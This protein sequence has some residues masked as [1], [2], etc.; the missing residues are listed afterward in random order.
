MV[1]LLA[2]AFISGMITILSPCI[3]P[4]LPIVL[5]GGSS[6]GK[7]RPFGVISGFVVSFS[8]FTLAL[9][10]IVQA[11]GMPADAMRYVAIALIVLFGIVMLVPQAARASST[12]RCRASRRDRSGERRRRRPAKPRAASGAGFRW[13]SAS[14]SYGLP[15]SGP[16][17]PRSSAS[18]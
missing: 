2:F 8:F 9:S 4:V 11:L 7:A 1:V 16:S 17:W 13:G 15:A 12:S 3:L 18:P 10:A 5:A 6:G 14:A